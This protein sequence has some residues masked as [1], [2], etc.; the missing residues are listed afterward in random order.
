MNK[1]KTILCY[2]NYYTIFFYD[3]F[4]FNFFSNKQSLL[5]DFL[6]HY[7]FFK[8]NNNLLHFFLLFKKELNFILYLSIYKIYLFFLIIIF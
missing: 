4:K 7:F 3:N 5:F 1:K 6:L 2:F 8:N